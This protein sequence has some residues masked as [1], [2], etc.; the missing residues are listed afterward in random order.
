M[1]LRRGA[2][3]LTGAAL[4]LGAAPAAY[5]QDGGGAAED[6][7]LFGES[8]PTYDGV[9]RQSLAVLA[10]RAEDRP[11][12]ENAV[13]WLRAQQCEDGSFAAYRADAGGECGEDVLAESNATAM[14]VQALTATRGADAEETRAALGWLLDIQNEDGGWPFSPGDP[15]DA[16]ST[17][18]VVGALVAAGEDVDAV[19]SDD[20]SSAYDALR[21]LQLGCDADGGAPGSFAWQPDGDS[22]ELFTNEA[23]TVDAALAMQG[24]GVLVDPVSGDERPAATECGADAGALPED[25]APRAAATAVA[26]LLDGEEGAFVPNPF[27]D[28]DPD[29]GATARAVL[30]LAAGG[31]G[32]ATEEPLAWLAENAQEWT[33]GSPAA[34]GQLILAVRAGDG[35]PAEFGGTDLTADLVALAPEADTAE[36]GT[37]GTDGGEPA[38]D[39]EED[40]DGGSTAGTVLLVVVGLLAGA[41]IGLLLAMRG[42]SGRRGGAASGGTATDSGTAAGS[43]ADDHRQGWGNSSDA[44]D[45]SGSSGSSGSDSSGGD[46]GGGGGD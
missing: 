22:G 3:A 5:A 42:R 2:A 15:T 30:A 7:G 26:E 39:A 12:P 27:A 25:E 10:L 43:T 13:D 9:W 33:A 28:G 19:T 44:S 34:L 11:V 18:A 17:A 45:S 41:G 40:G 36:D 46:S 16:N 14:A 29:V 38:S 32:G 20:G 21:A 37:D 6:A 1:K 24:S 31:Y 23:A 8:D 35:D 4:L